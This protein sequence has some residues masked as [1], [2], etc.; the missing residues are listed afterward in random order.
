MMRFYGSAYRDGR[1]WLAEIPIL[2]TMT[3]AHT[4]KEALAMVE[5]LL[6]TLANRPGFTVD[7]H[8]GKNDQFEISSPDTRTMTSLLLRRQRERSGLSLAEVA[9]RLGAKS[10]NT[11]ARYEQGISAPTLEKL[12]ELLNAVSPDRD[13][14][15]QQSS[16]TQ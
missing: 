14:V 13:L 16:L 9:D 2:D 1:F 6:V 3:Q 7:V 12:N 11:Y 4:R 10:R 8:A 5:N 15:L